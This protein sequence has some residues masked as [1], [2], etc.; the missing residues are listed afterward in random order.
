MGE[1]EVR[2]VPRDIRIRESIF[3]FD[4]KQYAAYQHLFCNSFFDFILYILPNIYSNKWGPF[5]YKYYN[6]INKCTAIQ[7]NRSCTSLKKFN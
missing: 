4:E 1:G 6:L 7:S 5:P 3:V 2:A